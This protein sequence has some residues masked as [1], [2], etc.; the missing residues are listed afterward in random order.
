M[1]QNQI[2]IFNSSND[3]EYIDGKKIL[4]EGAFSEV[5]KVR[6]KNNN[7]FYAL[8]KINLHKLSKADQ[9][10][11]KNETSLHTSLNHKNI[12]KFITSL[13]EE[14]MVYFLLEYAT[15]GCLFFYIHSRTGLPEMIALRY[16]YQTALAVKYLHDRNIIHRD[17]K[18]EN[19][20]LDGNFDVKLCDFGWSCE[21]EKGRA[22]TTVCGTYEYMSPEIIFLSKHTNKVD[23][24]CLG[25]LLYEML[26]GNPP[27]SAESMG[28]MKK[29]FSTKGIRINKNLSKDAKDLLKALLKRKEEN[30]LCIDEVLNQPA[31]VNNIEEFKKPINKK[32]FEILVKN[33]L[34]NSGGGIGRTMPDSIINNKNTDNIKSVNIPFY[35]ENQTN[36]VVNNKIDQLQQFRLSDLRANNLNSNYGK[37]VVNKVQV[38]VLDTINVKKDNE[39]LFFKLGPI[40]IEKKEGEKQKLE[41][42]K[43]QNQNLSVQKKQEIKIPKVLNNDNEKIISKIEINQS[44]NLKTNKI[45]ENT[46]LA[47]SNGNNIEKPVKVNKVSDKIINLQK[48]EK[49]LQNQKNNISV[50]NFSTTNIVKNIKNQNFIQTNNQKQNFKIQNNLQKNQNTKITSKTVINTDSNNFK[51][52]NIHSLKNIKNKQDLS[53]AKNPVNNN[54]GLIRKAEMKTEI[55]TEQKIKKN[56]FKIDHYQG[57]LRN[58]NLEKKNKEEIKIVEKLNSNVNITESN[59]ISRNNLT[60]EN[61]YKNLY[62]KNNENKIFE[63][64]NLEIKM[65]KNKNP[66][67]KIIENQNL[68]QKTVVNKNL[69]QKTIEDKNLDIK[70]IDNKNLN[71]KIIDYKNFDKIMVEKK[72]LNSKKPKKVFYLSRYSSLKDLSKPNYESRFSS[73]KNIQT[74]KTKNYLDLYSTDFYKKNKTSVNKNTNVIRKLTVKSRNSIIDTPDTKNKNNLKKNEIKEASNISPKNIILKESQNFDQ[75]LNKNNNQNQSKPQCQ[76]NI[77]KKAQNNAKNS[78]EIANK[79]DN[80]NTKKNLDQKEKQNSDTKI[81]NIYNNYYTNIYNTNIYEKNK[82]KNKEKRR[83]TDFSKKNYISEYGFNNDSDSVKEKKN[84]KIETHF[85]FAR[86]YSTRSLTGTRRESYNKN[87]LVKYSNQRSDFEVGKF[88]ENSRKTINGLVVRRYRI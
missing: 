66:D 11:L 48:K 31:F 73:N 36:P 63:N 29:E 33:F 60:K 68:V 26:H 54:L 56:F 75:K 1:N 84:G 2:P 81:N 47:V 64:K 71:K 83:D 14:N 62:Q 86:T 58:E 38:K 76:I 72:I 61:Y 43:I 21:T 15:N 30:R 22:R 74:Y 82:E 42:K 57:N 50:K 18:P 80:Q 87:G 52:K 59:K 5:V 79:K 37:D 65:T 51:N 49:N 77:T 16:A 10:H 23:I 3:L 55:K 7:K 9:A 28:D 85:N 46:K 34:I 27:F 70:R 67:L 53:L 78:S 39:K 24:W 69:D 44:K 20:L 12:I 40:I 45:I 32:E 17:I 25:I 41:I 88:E 35:G 13:Q 8:K 4:G 6:N 19:I